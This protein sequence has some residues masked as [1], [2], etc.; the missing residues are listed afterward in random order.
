MLTLQSTYH[1]PVVYPDFGFWGIFYCSRV[2]AD[3]YADYGFAP[4]PAGVSTTANGVYASVGSELIFDTRW[5]NIADI[6]MG[7]RFSL[8]L[9]HDFDEPVRKTRVEFV[10]PI[11]RL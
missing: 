2:R 3:L 9:T 11:I 8:F 1:F 6:P 7:V 5:F 10:L 4:V